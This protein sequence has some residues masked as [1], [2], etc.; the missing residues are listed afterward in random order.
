MIKEN[1]QS[2]AIIGAGISGIAAAIRMRNKGY[3]VSVFEANAF[4]GGKLSTESNKGYRFD[5]GPSVFTMPE[6]VDELIS[7][8]GKNPRDY[9]NYIPLDPVYRYFFED[10]AVMDAYHGKEKYA[11]GMA[12]KIKDKKEDI[13]KFR[14]SK[15]RRSHIKTIS[16]IGFGR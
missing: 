11:E 13:N 16:F 2:C 7:L 6:Y 4:P 8:S 12:S 1:N 3:S 10:G 5:M 15:Y 14:H 9:F